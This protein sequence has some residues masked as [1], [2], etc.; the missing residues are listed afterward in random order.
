MGDSTRQAVSMPVVAGVP[1]SFFWN[2]MPESQVRRQE[3]HATADAHKT[4]RAICS[5]GSPD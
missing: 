1:G 2:R 5:S 4:C 3:R